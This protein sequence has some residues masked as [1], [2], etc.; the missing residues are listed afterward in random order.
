LSEVTWTPEEVKA[1][2]GVGGK[3]K[4]GALSNSVRGWL[5]GGT[6]KAWQHGGLVVTMARLRWR[7]KLRRVDAPEGMI[8]RFIS[9]SFCG[10][11]KSSSDDGLES[12]RAALESENDGFGRIS[13]SREL[14]TGFG[15]LVEGEGM[16][17]NRAYPMTG[18]RVQ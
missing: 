3:W 7:G 13:G 5:F 1:G 15:Q 17:R 16:M 8:I 10:S 9:S 11:G 18:S 4:K 14:W 2:N 6:G 12:W